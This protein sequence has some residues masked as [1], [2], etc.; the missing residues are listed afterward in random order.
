M[1][2]SSAILLI[3]L[4]V[5][6]ACRSVEPVNTYETEDLVVVQ[7]NEYNNYLLLVYRDPLG[8]TKHVLRRNGVAEM[9]LTYTIEGEI[10]FKARGK[11][12]K[13]ID[14]VEAGRLTHRIN[15]LLKA[16]EDGGAIITSI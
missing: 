9:M 15:S 1:S 14:A 7:H 6:S 12:E 4:F 8:Q 11:K 16:S 2:R 5:L 10:K 13:T 3:V